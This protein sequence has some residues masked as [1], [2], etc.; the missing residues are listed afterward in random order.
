MMLELQ[1]ADKRVRLT[2]QDS[3]CAN[4]DR[5]DAHR[6]QSKPRLV[7]II[8]KEREN[9]TSL[10]CL[11]ATLVVYRCELRFQ[12]AMQRQTRRQ[13]ALPTPNAKSSVA[14]STL[15]TSARVLPQPVH[16]AQTSLSRCSGPFPPCRPTKRSRGPGN[17]TS[18]ICA[19]NAT[20]SCSESSIA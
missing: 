13:P 18:A 11:S 10:S 6:R 4:T 17:F 7:D 5:D 8:D 9:P 12:C 19:K 15:P 3:R 2:G 16:G 1:Q 14:C 20:R